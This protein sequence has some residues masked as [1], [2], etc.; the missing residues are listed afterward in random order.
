MSN[1]IR[2]ITRLIDEMSSILLAN[3]LSELDVKILPKD[4][5]IEIFFYHYQNTMS[6]EQLKKIENTL[7]KPRRLELETYYWTLV[8]ETDVDQSLQLVGGLTDSAKLTKVGNDVQ[9]IL[10]RADE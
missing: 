1:K 7:N 10:I 4:K 9:I 2:K 5:S 3:N 6:D 8:G